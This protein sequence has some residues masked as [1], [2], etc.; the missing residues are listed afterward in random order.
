MEKLRKQVQRA[1]RRLILEQFSTRLIWCLFAAFAVAAVAVAVPKIF[2]VAGLPANWS[3]IWLGSAAVA[4]VLSAAIWTWLVRRNELDAAIEIDLRYN[5]KE[6]VASSIS[7]NEHDIDSN[8]GRALVNDA[9]RQ[10]ERIE[11]R[12]K[13]RVGLDRRGWL[14]L[15]PAALAFAL[16][17]F[18]DDRTAQ[19]SAKTNVD[20]VLQRNLKN[21]AKEIRKKLQ[22]QKKEAEE[23]GLDEAGDLF[24]KLEKSTEDLEKKGEVD[25]KKALVKLNDLA[26]ELADRKK[27][28]GGEEGLQKQFE[29]LNKLGE[30]PAEKMGAALKQGDFQKAM[31]ELQ[32]LQEQIKAGELDE[33]T[34]KKL[35]EQLNQMKEQ[36]AEATENHKQAMEELQKELEQQR[37]AGNTAA[38]S[39]LQQKLD[40]LMQNKPQMEALQKLAQQ[41]GQCQQ[42]MQDGDQEGA[43]QAK[44]EMAQQLAQMQEQMDE[45]QMLDQMMMQLAEA[46]EA[47]QC[48]ECKGQ[49]CSMCQGGFMS[50]QFSEKGGNGMGAGRGYG[51]RPDEENDVAFRDSQVRAQP[52]KGR[53]VIKGEIDG[54][55]IKGA[56]LEAIKE[57]MTAASSEEADPLVN[58]RLPRSRREHAEEYFNSLREQ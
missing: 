46:K 14:P 1:R 11:V 29:K 40:K 54:P 28:I 4:G 43:A 3:A 49:G 9:V 48:S 38:A 27:E 7:L 16:V 20:P 32:K 23:K 39:E 33:E 44:Q 17:L 21:Q 50:N 42:C 34:K 35:Q 24:K 2:V 5:L 12:D 37:K 47:M 52:G 55:N 18:V 51:P 41:L 26:K 10:I 13:F 15:V 6:R 31:E 53:A 36:L 57:E 45:M 22:Q 19:S 25:R 8:V 30:G 58:Q 56:V